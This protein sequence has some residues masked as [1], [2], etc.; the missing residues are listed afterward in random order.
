ME[1]QP[2]EAEMR[3]MRC[4]IATPKGRHYKVRMLNGHLLGPNKASD[5]QSGDIFAT[6]WMPLPPAP[7]SPAIPHTPQETDT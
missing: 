1:W 6:H 5:R 3:N 7:L 2:I 4:L